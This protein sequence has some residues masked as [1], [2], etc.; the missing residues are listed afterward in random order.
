M[1]SFILL[2]ATAATTLLTPLASSAESVDHKALHVAHGWARASLGQSPNS[3]AYVTVHN[4]TQHGDKVVAVRCAAAARCEIHNHV[5]DGDV[6][7][8]RREEHLSVEPGAHIE[9]K[10]GGLH[11]M[12]FDLEAPLAAGEKTEITFVF[13][14]SGEVL[15]NADVLSIRDAQGRAQ[16]S[17]HEAHEKHNKHEKKQEH[18]HSPDHEHEKTKDHD[19]H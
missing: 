15:V 9:F 16:K 3:A 5:M 4:P 14:T 8:M 6:M 7:K 1:R 2:L 11:I 10:P 13:E 18:D 17:S 19:N 12:M